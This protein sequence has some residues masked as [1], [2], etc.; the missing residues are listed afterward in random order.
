[1]TGVVERFEGYLG[2]AA[3]ADGRRLAPNWSEMCGVSS[4]ELIEAVKK[5]ALSDL[6]RALSVSG[7]MVTF[8]GLGDAQSARL[9]AARAH[10]LCYANRFDEAVESIE[11]AE[12]SAEASGSEF[13]LGMVEIAAVQPL[14]RLGRMPEAESASRRA[15]ASFESCGDDLRTGKALLNLGVVLRMR[16]KVEESIT[17]MDRALTLVASDPFL[18][19]AIAS[20]RAESLQDLDRFDEAESS[21]ERALDAFDRAGNSHAA[22]I[23]EGNIADL[24]SRRGR[25]DAAL[26]RYE[27]ARTRFQ[28]SGATGDAARLAAEEAEVLGALGARDEACRA[29]ESCIALLAGTGLRR[30]LGRARLGLGMLLLGEGDAEA[31]ERLL[32]RAIGDLE[33]TD[34][35]VLAAVGRVALA[36]SS[37]RRSGGNSAEADLAGAL[38][39]LSALPA[40]FGQAAAELAESR[41]DAGDTERAA[42][43]FRMALEHAN[44]HRL[45]PLRSRCRHGLARL[46]A[47]RGELGP[48][49]VEIGH[50]M[51]EADALRGALRAEQLRVSFAQSRR[52]VFLDAFSIGLDLGERGDDRGVDLAFEALERL[53]ARS[54]LDAVGSSHA[55]IRGDATSEPRALAEEREEVVARIDRH[56]ANAVSAGLP[57]ASDSVDEDELIALEERASELARRIATHSSSRGLT[58]E[59]LALHGAVSALPEGAAALLYGIDRGSLTCMVLCHSGHKFRRRVCLVVDAQRELERAAFF[60]RDSLRSGIDSEQWKSSL[61]RLRAMLLSPVTQE[62]SG[63]SR[64]FVSAPGELASVP[65]RLLLG[66]QGGRVVTLVP[67]VSAAVRISANGADDASG[68]AVFVGVSDDYAPGAEREAVEA[69]AQIPGACVLSGSSAH[70]DSVLSMLPEASVLHIATHCVYSPRHPMLTRLRLWDRWI[71]ARD[72][73]R[74]LRRGCRVVLAGCD[75]GQAAGTAE[76]RQGLVYA[77]LAAGAG[78][79]LASMWALH[80]E[81]ARRLFTDFYGCLAASGVYRGDMSAALLKAQESACGAGEPAHRWGGLTVIGGIT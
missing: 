1:M 40:R 26:G 3:S 75:T 55:N 60:L 54:L 27:R 13:E 42:Q 63:A 57:A 67:S 41:L 2:E 46:H 4:D 78:G 51:R 50:A 48:A 64:L 6:P 44:S 80:D 35:G 16:G 52:A 7:S 49:M 59:P 39:T 69:A 22:A 19:A 58:S 65:W 10:V 70:S 23:V 32:A 8:V 38:R 12:R 76:E 9:W 61:E 62:L 14:A 68:R 36:S 28:S 24:L 5:L 20:N 43:E 56:Y 73:T 45:T 74:V 29:Y 31:G 53:R 66:A 34:S 81:G 79:V 72:L 15:V 25:F 47:L 18:T 33:E 37:I 11:A 17:V 77:L 21:F 71:T 30:E